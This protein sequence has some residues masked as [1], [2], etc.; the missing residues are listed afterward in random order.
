MIGMSDAISLVAEIEGVG[1]LTCGLPASGKTTFARR[2]ERRGFLRI[3]IDEI[4]WERHGRPGVDFEQERYG[5]VL[6]EAREQLLRDVERALETPQAFVVDS[7]FW[8][9]AHRDR[10]RSLFTEHR[11][12]CLLVH[13][14]ATQAELRERLA[15][16]NQKR[17]ADAPIVID[18]DTLGGLVSTFEAPAA[19]EDAITVGFRSGRGRRTVRPL[20]LADFDAWLPLWTGYNAFY[21][22]PSMPEPITQAA[23]SRFMDQNAP[24]HVI[25]MFGDDALLGIAQFLFLGHHARPAP[26]CWRAL[27]LGYVG[28]LDRGTG[29][30]GLSSRDSGL[31]EL[32]HAPAFH[33]IIRHEQEWRPGFHRDRALPRP[34]MGREQRLMEWRVE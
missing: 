12:R 17:G 32:H 25:G 7:S 26:R 16:R 22:R 21:G 3:S 15:V 27:C 9:R 29:C 14:V 23:W 19:D 30:N 1:V 5:E 8:S 2:L 4:V 24:M 34:A 31:R 11:R 18:D 6:S 13:M 20:E 33:A 28:G 10:F